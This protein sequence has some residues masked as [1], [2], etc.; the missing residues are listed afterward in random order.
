MSINLNYQL[1]KV[2]FAGAL[3][4]MC[5]SL[6]SC[7]NN[8]NEAVDVIPPSS[9]DSLKPIGFGEK[10]IGGT[11]QNITV[12]T[13]AEQL[14]EA[15]SGAN[16]A[17][18]YVQGDITLDNMLA[19]GSNKSIIGLYGATISN[20]NCNE[21]AGIFLLKGSNNVIIRNLTL[22]GPGAYDI[23]ANYSDNISLVG[24]KNVWVDHCDIQ[25]GIDG[26]FDIVEGSD[27]ICVSWTRFHYLIEPL[28]GG[29]G[30]S[31][32]H[33]NCN[34]IGNSNNTADLDEGNLNC[35]FICCWWGEGCV[36]RCPRVRFGKVHVVNCLYDGNDFK[37]CVGYGV[38]S[39]IY[40]EKCAF[41]SE[42]AKKKALKDYRGDKDVNIKVVDCL[43]IDDVELSQGERG[44][45]VPSYNY[46]AFDSSM[47]ESVLKDPR[48]GAGATI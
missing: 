20:L 32:D 38:Y 18:I 21:N 16:P 24:A 11:N 8:D 9:Y 7:S 39:N 45:F 15:V 19:V 31:S 48:N 37:Y 29:S 28:E 23:D 35:T 6:S 13:N 1:T 10:T 46:K 27:S 40:V 2:F 47:V 14:A 26:N 3:L 12:V 25:D 33:R 42:K 17:T 34:L 41:V 4:T 5:F 30:G 36:E 44:Q 22:L 43:G